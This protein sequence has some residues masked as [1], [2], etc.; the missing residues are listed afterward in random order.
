MA[1][2]LART[3]TMYYGVEME[4]F[5]EYKIDTRFDAD[6]LTPKEFTPNLLKGLL[7]WSIIPQEIA[8]WILSLLEDNI[9]PNLQQEVLKIIKK[10]V[11]WDNK[12][13]TTYK[14]IS[15]DHEHFD[16]RYVELNAMNVRQLA[17][18]IQSDFKDKTPS[19][20]SILTIIH[21]LTKK[22]VDSYPKKV[23]KKGY[24]TKIQTSTGFIVSQTIYRPELIDITDQENEIHKK[25]IISDNDSEYN[26]KSITQ[27]LTNLQVDSSLI[28]KPTSKLPNLFPLNN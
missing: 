6:T 2:E 24:E 11:N 1:L 14:I 8:V 27:G 5:S 23:I 4:L 25:E 26:I 17:F 21:H 10:K 20:Y 16:R 28:K 3:Y 18:G 12:N 9:L 19:I 22:F 13:I 7:K 15:D